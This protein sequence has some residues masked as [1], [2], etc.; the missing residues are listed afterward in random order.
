MKSNDREPEMRKICSRDG[1]S[2]C[3]SG[4]WRHH[5]AQTGMGCSASWSWDRIVFWAAL[6]ELSELQLFPL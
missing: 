2:L 1:G 5:V 4:Q 6:G 3:F